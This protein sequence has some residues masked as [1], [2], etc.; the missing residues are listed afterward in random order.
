[1]NLGI[2]A[3][4]KSTSFRPLN[5][6]AGRGWAKTWLAS[7]LESALKPDYAQLL[8]TKASGD[9][10]GRFISGPRAKSCFGSQL[11]TELR[12]TLSQ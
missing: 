11:E 1:M 5:K 8:A 4:I 12:E 9:F 2:Q 7:E 3:E 6:L 10:S